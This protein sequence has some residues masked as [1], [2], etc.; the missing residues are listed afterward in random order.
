MGH[1]AGVKRDFQA[2]ERRRLEAAKLLAQ[3]LPEAEVAR[4]VGVHR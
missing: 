3:G 2:L 1:P 4:R